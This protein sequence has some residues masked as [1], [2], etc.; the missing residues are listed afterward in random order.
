MGGGFFRVW[1]VLHKPAYSFQKFFEHTITAMTRLPLPCKNSPA[2]T[3]MATTFI[4][5]ASEVLALN[6]LIFL[7]FLR[8]IF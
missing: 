8:S 7:V 2:S 6:G 4:L 1:E 3:L 5:V